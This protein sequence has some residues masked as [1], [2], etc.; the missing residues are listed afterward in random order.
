MN[1]NTIF[2]EGYKEQSFTEQGWYMRNVTFIK[3]FSDKGLVYSDS[4]DI[5][6][7]GQ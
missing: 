2:E 3:S 1:D 7:E 5:R 6:V 4:D